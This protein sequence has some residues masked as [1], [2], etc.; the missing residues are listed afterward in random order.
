[1]GSEQPLLVGDDDDDIL[2]GE[3]EPSNQKK[4]IQEID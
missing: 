2:P 1:V 4:N 3:K